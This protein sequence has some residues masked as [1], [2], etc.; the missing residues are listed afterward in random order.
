MK[1]LEGIFII[2]LIFLPYISSE[3]NIPREWLLVAVL[4]ASAQFFTT[5]NLL[6]WTAEQKPKQYSIYQLS[7]TLFTTILSLIFV[8]GI[9][10]GWKGQLLA[11]ALSILFFAML[12]FI[13][14]LKRGYF[15]LRINREYIIDAL[16]FGIPLIPHSLSGWI[17]TSIDRVLIMSFFG[18]YATGL[19]TVGYQ[20]GM[21]IGVLTTAFHKAWTPYIMNILSNKPSLSTKKRLVKYTYLYFI[22]ILCIAF[23]FT[24]LAQWA[25]PYFLDSKYKN[26]GEYILYIALSFAFNGM[27]FMVV[28]Y[29]FYVQKTYF[30]AIVT[31]IV[32]ILHIGI[33]YIL[34]KLN[35]TIGAAQS[36]M[37]ASLISFVATWWFSQKVYK[38]PWILWRN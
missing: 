34:L 15:I 10:L 21:I 38:M 18:S 1:R 20:I 16:R 26:S 3:T 2:V 11:L 28:N 25:L 29:I 12:S 17:S 35:G 13:F 9:G 4:L 32:S 8:V 23:V 24:Y 30:L 27:Y 6:L 19:Y 31:F 22:L 37:I 5:I 7:Q 36:A 33:L 14:I